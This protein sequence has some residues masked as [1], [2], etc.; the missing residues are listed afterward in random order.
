[1]TGF[2]L[3]TATSIYFGNSA[4]SEVYFGSNKIWPA[5]TVDYTT[6]PLTFE[7]VEPGKFIFSQ[8]AT[9]FT[10]L[11]YSI[12]GG[13]ITQLSIN[14]A[15]TPTLQAGD[16][17]EWY[18]IGYS[19]TDPRGYFSSTGRFKVYGNILSILMSSS[20]SGRTDFPSSTSNNIF[21]RL[22]R[23][24]KVIDASNLKL[25]VS[26]LTRYCFAS[27]FY[28]CQYLV[29]PPELLATSLRAYCYDSMFW[30]CSS[31]I[32]MPIGIGDCPLPATILAEGC[33]QYMFNGCTSLASPGDVQ[34]AIIKMLP[35]KTLYPH[36]YN[37]MFSGCTSFTEALLMPATT[38]VTDCYG[39]MFNGCTRLHF[40]ACRATNVTDL[41]TTSGYVGAWTNNVAAHGTFAKDSNVTWSYGIPSGWTILSIDDYIITGYH[42]TTATQYSEL[43]AGEAAVLYTD[44]NGDKITSAKQ[45][46][47]VYVTCDANLMNVDPMGDGYWQFDNASISFKSTPNDIN[48]EPDDWDD[49]MSNRYFIMPA[50][51]VHMIAMGTWIEVPQEPEPEPEPEP[52][53][54]V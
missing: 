26:N 10:P 20:Y 30:G 1:M 14:G 18:G 43:S 6:L 49:P 16:K 45:G 31:L 46:D 5:S 25:P 24:A 17:V 27:M 39:G 35:A 4:I 12:N 44:V 50:S 40:I 51:S 37:G 2:D 36:C 41:V 8:N 47:K 28:K 53:E 52:E 13:P 15:G 7:A 21:Q 22:F 32:R 29:Y 9:E 33:Y 48:V 54:G 38:L 34:H 19:F 11:S 42:L 3:S 23:E